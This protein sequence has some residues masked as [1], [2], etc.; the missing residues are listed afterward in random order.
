VI[1]HRKLLAEGLGTALLLAAIVGSGIMG[2][3]LAQGNVAITLLVNSLATG[4]MLFVLISLFAP[5][6]GA[7][8]NPAVT[9]VEWMRRRITARDGL[10]YIAIQIV[11]AYAGVAAANTMF[12]LP[13]FFAA[14][15][16]RTG[17]AQ[18]WSEF[19]AA[20][21]LLLTIL[22]GG[23]LAPRRVAALVACYVTAAY[24]FTA[25]TSFA[26]PAV[27]MARAAS[28]TFSGIRPSDTHAF[29]GAQ[30]LGALAAAF[31]SRWLMSPLA[32]VAALAGEAPRSASEPRNDEE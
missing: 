9:L 2:E 16:V 25:S 1:L 26:N 5:I 24:W 23:R 3:R 22:L 29:I 30:L 10:L 13:I 4:A 17:M 12:D 11:G 19:I 32:A 7:H 18:W 20:F 15:H 27:T 31:L 21:G 8:L 6:S 14:T 28:D